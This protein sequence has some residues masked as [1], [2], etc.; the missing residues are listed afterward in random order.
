MACAQTSERHSL[1]GTVML[2][3]MLD[4]PIVL[5]FFCGAAFKAL[6]PN[7]PARIDSFVAAFS[8]GTLSNGAASPAL[9]RSSF[10]NNTARTKEPAMWAE[11]SATASESAKA[12]E[13]NTPNVPKPKTMPSVPACTRTLPDTN[14][15]QW[16][17]ALPL[18]NN[19]SGGSA[20]RCGLACRQNSTTL[21]SRR[22]CMSASSSGQATAPYCLLKCGARMPTSCSVRRVL[23]LAPRLAKGCASHVPGTLS[24]SVGEASAVSPTAAVV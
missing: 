8:W 4:L 22:I 15:R 1:S 10:R 2:R 17:N 18:L 11:K 7:A 6:S 14:T 9:V 13:P 20:W 23:A 16:P 24:A 21:A 12:A 5:L 3:P 19:Q